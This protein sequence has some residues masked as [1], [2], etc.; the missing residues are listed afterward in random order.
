MK[1]R[2]RILAVAFSVC[3]AALAA[4]AGYIQIEG[5]KELG[6]AARM[7]QTLKINGTDTRSIIY[8]RNGARITDASA[9]Y[10][11]I[12][13]RSRL[14]MKARQLLEAADAVEG[15]KTN[16]TYAI[17]HTENKNQN[18]RESLEKS[19]N[20][21][22]IEAGSRYSASQQLTFWGISAEIRERQ[23]LRPDT[24]AD[25]TVRT[26]A[27]LYIQTARAIYLKER[28]RMYP[29]QKM[30]FLPPL[31]CRCRS[32]LK[33]SWKHANTT[34]PPLYSKQKQ[35]IYLQWQ[36]PLTTVRSR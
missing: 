21:Y 24:R 10:V 25:F 20:A 35:A 29:M 16:D 1:K 6:D 33:K 23:A 27:S 31:T 8:D 22:V 9:N 12:I 7:Q 36:A 4:R 15:D 17:Y 34:L 13:R 2:I 3:L 26:T 28:V 5:H 11:Y 32:L 18:I 30:H 19:Y 14:D